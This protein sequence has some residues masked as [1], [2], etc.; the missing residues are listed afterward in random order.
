MSWPSTGCSDEALLSTLTAV[1]GVGPWTVDMFS[2]FHLGRPDVLP[3]G[4]LGVRKVRGAGQRPPTHLLM[5]TCSTTDVLGEGAVKW[6]V[7]SSV[8]LFVALLP[9]DLQQPCNR[10]PLTPQCLRCI[11][12]RCRPTSH[13]HSGAK[14][15][16]LVGFANNTLLQCLSPCCYC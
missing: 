1:R 15:T 14:A 8:E 9:S 10:P 16:W 2:M 4:D 13:T 12:S 7:C 6:G 3:V 11:S 5:Q